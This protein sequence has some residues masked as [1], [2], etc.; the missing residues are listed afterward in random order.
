MT[1]E[2]DITDALMRFFGIQPLP[3]EGG[4]YTQTYQSPELIGRDALP[5]R[6]QTDKPLGTAILYLYTTDPDCF[7]A[8]HRLPTDEIYH[9]YLGDPVEMLLLYPDGHA[10]RVVLGQDVFNG[11]QVQFLAPK[12]VWQAS[13]L[14]A[15]GRY[16]LAG[17]TMA[18]GYTDGDYEG[19][20]REALIRQ[21][22]GEAELIRRLT[23]I[24][25]G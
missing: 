15:S 21:Y 8:L 1:G 3:I 11:Q 20:E 7:S 17:T 23:R 9:F 25:M 13:H 2:P 16:A 6:Y 24:D 12:G 18:P 4:F 10:Q 5:E 19:G 22:P 14:I